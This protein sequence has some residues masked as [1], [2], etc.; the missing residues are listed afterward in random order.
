MGQKAMRKKPETSFIGPLVAKDAPE[1]K[2]TK[3]IL[4]NDRKIKNSAHVNTKFQSWEVFQRAGCPGN[5][6][7]QE[8]QEKPKENQEI[9]PAKQEIAFQWSAHKQRDMIS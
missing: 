6:E 9:R 7:N 3:K 5:Q 1:I 8:N 2:K 4:K